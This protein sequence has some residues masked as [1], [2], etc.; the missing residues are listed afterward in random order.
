MDETRGTSVRAPGTHPATGEPPAGGGVRPGPTPPPR[1]WSRRGSVLGRLGVV[2]VLLAVVF[3]LITVVGRHVDLGAGPDRA[4]D[5]PALQVDPAPITLGAVGQ[6]TA[7]VPSSTDTSAGADPA[8]AAATPTSGAATLAAWADRLAGPTD[9]PARV[10]QAYGLADL[11]L[12]RT[13][14]GCHL[15]W[16]TVA[17]LGRIES[18]HGRFHGAGVRA[19]GEVTPPIVGVPLD[20]TD[21]NATIVGAGGAYSQALGPLQFLPTTWARWGTDTHGTGHADINNI[22]DAAV[23]AARYL[24]AD[25]HDLATGP[26]W[27]AAVLSYNASEDYARRVYAAAQA[28]AQDRAP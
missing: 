1:A 7:A 3:A 13:E 25:G 8:T 26:G 20:G 28:Y 11:A 22:D 4:S 12:R 18:D 5:I 21:G 14:P 19:D 10:L 17:G 16:V 23:T 27:S 9:I 24:C 2:L 6:P 15:S